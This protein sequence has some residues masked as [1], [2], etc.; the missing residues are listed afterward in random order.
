MKNLSYSLLYLLQ[1][2]FFFS[3]I[4]SLSKIKRAGIMSEN[5]IDGSSQSVN[6]ELSDHLS[7]SEATLPSSLLQKQVNDFV[8]GQ[9]EA[10][11]Q[12]V[13]NQISLIDKINVS[14]EIELSVEGSIAVKETLEEPAAVEETLEE[15]AAVEETLEG[16]V[17]GEAPS[18]QVIE[19]VSAVQKKLVNKAGPRKTSG[20][21]GSS[22]RRGGY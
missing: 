20:F 18:Q 12:A 2:N 3:I 1:R 22:S 15:P 16:P 11:K 7:L 6:A 10:L 4:Y 21:G 17:A 19:S 13:D 9:L 14:K 8:L 5:S